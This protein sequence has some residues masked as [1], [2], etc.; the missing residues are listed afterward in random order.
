MLCAACR[1]RRGKNWLPELLKRLLPRL[2]KAFRKAKIRIRLDAGFTGPELYDFFEAERLEYVVCMGKNPVLQRF[3]EPVMAPLREALEAG[4]DLVPRFGE[5]LY[6]AR[7]WKCQR[8]VIIKAD[9]ALHPG[10]KP[11]DNPR[12]IVT[13]LTLPRRSCIYQKVSVR[14]AISRIASR[15]QTRSG[16]Q[17][18]P[19]AQASKPTSF[20]S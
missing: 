6:G 18:A 4:A 17:I 14:A 13:N 3:A 9:I 1:Q 20:G 15:T 10:R 16:D 5:C 2:R 7:S 12:F 19:V 8:R 11:K